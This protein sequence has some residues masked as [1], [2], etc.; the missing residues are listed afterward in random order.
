MPERRDFI[1]G[2]FVAGISVAGLSSKLALGASALVKGSPGAARGL[3]VRDGAIWRMPGLGDGYK[4]SWGA[5]GRQF[6]VLN[7]GTG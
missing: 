7:D 5:D 6:V 4:M 3:K 2:A 1:K